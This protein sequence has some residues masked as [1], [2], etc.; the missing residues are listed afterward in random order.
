[1]SEDGANKVKSR[2]PWTYVQKVKSGRESLYISV[3]SAGDPPRDAVELAGGVCGK[4]RCN[5]KPLCYRQI[6][7]NDGH[8][9]YEFSCSQHREKISGKK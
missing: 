7:F 2:G 8:R 3:T 5:S 4:A 1:M 9:G 6:R